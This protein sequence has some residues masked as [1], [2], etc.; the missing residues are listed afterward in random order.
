[1]TTAMISKGF[2]NAEFLP[3]V[4]DQQYRE[5]YTSGAVNRKIRG[6]IKT[7]IYCGFDPVPGSG[8]N[9]LLQVDSTDGGSSASID[10]GLY[11]QITI[12]QQSEIAVPVIAGT[13]KK[14]V[15]QGSYLM[16]VDTYQVNSS[17]TVSAAEIVLLD[18]GTTLEKNQLELCTVTVPAGATQITSAMIDISGRIVRTMGVSLS[19]SIT[20]DSETVAANSKAIHLLK[21]YA[22]S[23]FAVLGSNS[24][25]TTLNSLQSITN[26][27]T[28]TKPVALS[29]SLTVAGSSTFISDATFG[30]DVSILGEL[31]LLSALSIDNGGTG[32][33]TVADALTALCLDTGS[34]V[35]SENAYV[36]D[37]SASL[38]SR[39]EGQ[40]IKFR[41]ATT[42]TGAST[43][44]DGVGPAPLVGGAHLALQGGEMVAGG[45]A[46]AQWNSTVGTGSYILLRCTGAPTQVADATKAKHAVSKSQLDAVTSVATEVLAGISRK[47][48][49]SEEVAG[50][51]DVGFLTPLGLRNAMN[52]TGSAPIFAVR[53]WA[54]FKQVGTQTIK[55]SGNVLS[56]TDI[57]VGRSTLTFA[58]AMSDT[59]YAAAGVP[60]TQAGSTIGV[61]TTTPATAEPALKLVGS[62]Q[63]G[64]W[65]ASGALV[66]FY[67]TSVM[68]L[69]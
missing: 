18:V 31:S 52:A 21:T 2:P 1:M 64:C 60:T 35:G 4:A 7:G 43:F 44:N 10:I 30:S 22:D 24:D 53:A 36:C 16:G 23:K 9:V 33:T 48:T 6:I 25:I 20:S 57:A 59:N 26:E 3:L 49:D 28:A 40:V 68:F 42:N 11:Y 66:D 32:A 27:F 5:P 50:A 47:A 12:R 38:P 46:L 51:S 65:D 13:T 41:V 15:L 8:L 67:D 62:C 14:I 29:D 69:R 39:K 55:A 63:V 34:D 17:S 58:T 54:C 45:D 19:N 37:V 56:I 61:F